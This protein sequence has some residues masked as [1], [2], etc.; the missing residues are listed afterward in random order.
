MSL[1][2][3]LD[4][5]HPEWDRPHPVTIAKFAD[6]PR[7][8]EFEENKKTFIALA[9]AGKLVPGKSYA[10]YKGELFGPCDTH[11]KASDLASTSLD[12]SKGIGTFF[13]D[14]FVDDAESSIYHVL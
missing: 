2:E 3:A 10:V 8:D 9:K 5:E 14:C 7:S 1:K 13:W 12:I 4:K 6:S 11:R